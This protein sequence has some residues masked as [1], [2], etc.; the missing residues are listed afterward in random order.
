MENKREFQEEDVE[1]EKKKQEKKE[2][3]SNQW[4]MGEKKPKQ[5]KRKDIEKTG[6]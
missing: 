3:K 6:K 5:R 4:T 1:K 2:S